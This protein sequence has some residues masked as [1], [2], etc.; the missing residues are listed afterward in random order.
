[1]IMESQQ[2]QEIFQIQT[3]STLLHT[4]VKA[5]S[6]VFLKDFSLQQVS[7]LRCMY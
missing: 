1:M 4:P 5:I 6:V 2:T 3:I 7:S